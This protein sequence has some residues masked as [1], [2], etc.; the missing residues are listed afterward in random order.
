MTARKYDINNWF[1]I[2]DNPLSRE[3]IFPY[4]GAQ[5]GA[6]AHESNRI[7]RVYRPAEEL[8][9]PEALASF[10]LLPIIDDHEMIGGAHTPAETKGVAG[11]IGE[12]ISFADGMMRGNLKIFSNDLAEKIKRGKK[13]LS[14]GYRCV[15]DFTP[16]EWNGQQYDVVQRHIRGNHLALVTEGRMGPDVAVLD[17][18]IFT[19]DA[20]EFSP[21]DEQLKEMLAA[22]VARLDKLEAATAPKTPLTGDMDPNAPKDP[23]EKPP[24]TADADPNAPKDPAEKP[25]VTADADPNAPKDDTTAM[26]A[27]NREIAAL[28][29]QISELSGR[30][31]MD[32]KTF[33]EISAKKSALVAKLQPLVGVFDSSAMTYDGVVKYGV[34]KLKVV[35]PAGQEGVALDA[36]LQAAKPA[37]PYSGTGMDAKPSGLKSAISTYATGA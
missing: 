34:E 28:K 12:A 35:A 7:F 36:Y 32:E 20:K 2:S 25:P 27:A 31:T 24:V 9:K 5:I 15:Y 18:M 1:E 29:K 13:E 19:V 30:P 14:C 4:S 22:I 16:G 6:A 17:H 23:D 10:R 11:V 33:V 3:G 21:V 8:E 26:D 37:Q